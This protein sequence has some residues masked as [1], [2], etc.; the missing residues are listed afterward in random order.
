MAR[1]ACR[2]LPPLD[3]RRQTHIVVAGAPVR[4]SP[5]SVRSITR[6]TSYR[7]ETSS[8]RKMLRRWVSIVLT[9]RNSSL[10]ISGLVR[11]STTRSAT[12][13]SRC[14]R[15]STPAPLTLPGR[16]RWWM[17]RPACAA[18]ARPP[19]GSAWRR[20]DRAAGLPAR[21]RRPPARARPL[22]PNA[23][24]ARVRA[25][26]ASTRAPT[27]SAA[28]TKARAQLRPSPDFRASAHRLRPRGA[29]SQP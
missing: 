1:R 4:L 6:A 18:P 22:H 19:A 28:A 17:R 27:S 21:A 9:L 11:R 29:P 2:R 25:R 15:V 24:P 16:V 3:R 13:T 8:L 26:A 12:W 5:P 7:D 10:A 14:V 23:L 20:T